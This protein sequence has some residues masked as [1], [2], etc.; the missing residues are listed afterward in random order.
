ME[1]RRL[2]LASLGAHRRQM[3]PHRRGVRHRSLGAALPSVAIF[4]QLSILQLQRHMDCQW[5]GRQCVGDTWRLELCT[6][7]VPV[8]WCRLFSGAL[9][10]GLP[11]AQDLIHGCLSRRQ[12]R[13]SLL[14]IVNGLTAYPA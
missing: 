8:R 4:S 7:Y 14:K 2:S 1:Q 3:L 13:L 5:T 10:P 6:G 12:L 11:A 9:M